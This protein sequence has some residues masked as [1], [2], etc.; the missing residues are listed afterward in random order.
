MPFLAADVGGT[1]ARVALVRTS[2]DEG[3]EIE[4]LA[5]RKF[6]CADFRGLAELLQTFVDVDARTPVR[7]CVIACAGQVIGNEVLHDNSAWPIHLSQLRQALALDDIGV[8]ND[9]EAL[10]YALDYHADSSARL[11][12]GPDT[13]VD[14][15]ALVI[16]PGTGLGAAVRLPC[17]AGDHVLTTEAGQMDFAPNSIREREVLAH[18]APNGGY[19]AYEHIV[20]GPGLL[21]LYSALCTLRGETPKLST[22]EAVTDAAVTCSDAQAVEA[23]EIFCASLGNFAGSLAMT[24]MTLGGVYLAGGFLYSLF[25][26]LERSAFKERFLHGRSARAFLSRVPVWVTEHG[27]KGVLGAAKWYLRRGLSGDAKSSHFSAAG[28]TR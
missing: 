1:Y 4:V 23:V 13:R 21:T 14:G 12:C 15:P 24:F 17:T 6:A 20:S 26:L 5:Y 10:G 19:V 7:H 22:P 2:Q 18:L 16:G 28:L 25:A 9:F 8:L 3:H 11:L 27:R